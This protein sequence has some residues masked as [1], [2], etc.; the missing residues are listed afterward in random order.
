MPDRLFQR[1]GG[2]CSEQHGTF[3]SRSLWVHF[4]LYLIQFRMD[5]DADIVFFQYL[6]YIA[7]RV[8]HQFRDIDFGTIVLLLHG[9]LGMAPSCVRS[10]VFHWLRNERRKRFSDARLGGWVC[11]CRGSSGHIAFDS[12]FVFVAFR[13]FW[14][15]P[16]HPTFMCFL[17]CRISSSALVPVILVC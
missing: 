2:W 13:H 4:S 11:V 16:A 15:F 8:A 5:T 12:L 10:V 6:F 7:T 9:G 1:C 14:T 17:G 3:M